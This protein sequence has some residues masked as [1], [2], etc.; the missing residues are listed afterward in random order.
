MHHL[1]AKAE[2]CVS[3]SMSVEENSF[4]LDSYR[5]L[6]NAYYICVAQGVAYVLDALEIEYQLEL[7]TEVP[8][9][10]FV[11]QPDHHGVWNRIRVPAVVSPAMWRLDDFDVLPNLVRRINERAIDCIRQLA[12]ADILV[13]S[14]SSFSYVGSILNRDGIVL[15]HPF[16]HRPL[17]SW[18]TVGPDGH[19][20]QVKFQK[21]VKAL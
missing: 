18:I 19:F 1:L 15:Y 4:V 5:M 7:Y 3:P 17:S 13:I 2:R 16:W 9:N 12:T 8:N 14:R 11:V 10:E 21:A 20:D 6:P